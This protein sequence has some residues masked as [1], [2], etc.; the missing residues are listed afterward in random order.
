MGV[1]VQRAAV[2]SVVAAG[3][4]CGTPPRVVLEGEVTLSDLPLVVTPT[5]PLAAP[6]F[7]HHICVA[8]AED[9]VTPQGDSLLLAGGES[10]RLRLVLTTADGRRDSLW[11]PG[12]FFPDVD[13]A[14]RLTGDSIFRP[15]YPPSVSNGTE[16]VCVIGDRALDPTRRVV[17]LE[18]R[19]DRPLPI[20]KVTWWSGQPR[21]VFF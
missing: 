6:G 9:G 12:Y 14:G 20:R 8:P 4:A 21:K 19:S 3:L 18:L 2:L 11:N 17:R 5:R 7:R 13:S 10:T 15:D 16:G 1:M